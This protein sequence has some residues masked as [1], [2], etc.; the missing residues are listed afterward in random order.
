MTEELDT[1]V[2]KIRADTSALAGD[3]AE[4]KAIFTASADGI[5]EAFS[6]ALAKLI[7]RGKLGFED[8][9]KLLRE[10]LTEIAKIATAIVFGTK[11]KGGSSSSLA[12]VLTQAFGLLSASGRAAGG[13]VTQGR[14]YVVGE[15]G[16]EIFVPERA[17]RIETLH[18]SATS[19]P[20][21]ISI[22][23]AAPDSASPQLMQR[24]AR[25]IA[26]AVRRAVLE[27]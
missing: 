11:D 20:I 1:L 19:R 2:L 18:G 5:V 25:Q 24:S 22:H 7:T 4:I 23:V 13:P 10:V 27:G 14:A 3:A 12:G 17:G 6:D 26:R 16:P 21:N 15:R 8:W 9:K